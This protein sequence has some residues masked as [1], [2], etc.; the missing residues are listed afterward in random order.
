MWRSALWTPFTLAGTLL[1]ASVVGY[2]PKTKQADAYR[3]GLVAWRTPG[4][5]D[6]H[7]CAQ[8]H[9]PDGLEIAMYDFDDAALRRRAKAH[10]DDAQAEKVV[11]LIHAVREKLHI[12]KPLNPFTD[13]PFQPG[14]EVLPGKTPAERD[15]AFGQELSV[16]LPMLAKGKIKS[17]AEAKRA[18]DA[19][20]ALNPWQLR[21]GIPFNR[22]SEDSF[23]G[24][25][26]ASLAHWLPDVARI[27]P[28]ENEAA[29]YALQDAYLADPSDENLWKVYDGFS[30][31][32][33]AP[34]TM[35]IATVAGEKFRS[36]L[37]LQ[38]SYRRAGFAGE[39]RKGPI[40]FVSNPSPLVPNPMWEIG[41]TARTFQ[42][43][44]AEAFGLDKDELAKKSGG[45]SFK[46]Q[47]HDIQASWFWLGWLFDQGL[48]RTS[49]NAMSARGDWLALSLGNDGHYP[50]H[51][52]YWLTR[53]QLVVNR[54]PGAWGG[55][56]DRKR[57]EWDYL[58]IRVG[59]RY[60]YEMPKDPV[61]HAAYANFAS[62]CFRMTLYLMIEDWRKTKVVWY[63]SASLSHVRALTQFIGDFQPGSAA[64]AAALKKEAEAAIATCEEKY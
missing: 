39:V 29:W 26:H 40:A 10:L 8:C 54:V 12:T 18:A 1:T 56:P 11:S 58:A 51:N 2:A 62:N 60:V 19:V 31:L 13:R 32:T 41:E 15:L 22:F 35:G 16:K 49:R 6:G 23:H 47:M 48:E 38:H 63:R 21:I 5:V 14:G 44:N 33:K 4:K 50:I 57:A 24:A 7:A 36:L 27:I 53:K 59:G 28:A 43:I 55:Q 52:V 30:A 34:S 3:E 25:E 9:G 42:D 64:D 46:Q 20:M 37:L 17:L 61:Y 45:P